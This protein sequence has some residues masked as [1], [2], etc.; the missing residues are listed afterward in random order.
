MKPKQIFILAVIFGLLMAAV[1]VKELQKP[2]E[3]TEEEYISL[4]LSFD[5]PQVAKILIGK[6]QEKFVELLK[7]SHVWRIPELWNA[8]ADSSKVERFLQGIRD[9][10]GELR[11]SDK[12]LFGDFGI[13][14]DKAFSVLLLKETGEPVLK[15]FLGTKK[16][17][18]RFMFVRK[19]GSEKVYLTETDL[20][21]EMG[22]LGDPETQNPQ[23]EHWAGLTFSEL[24]TDKIDRLEARRF[25]KEKETLT[26]SIVRTSNPSDPA[27]KE[28]KYARETV[29]AAMDQ[30]KIK[31]FLNFLTNTYAS[32]VLDPTAYNFG[33]P[34]WQMKIGLEDGK[35]VILNAIVSDETTK[36]YA[37][38]V[39]TEPVAFQVSKYYFEDLDIE[40]SKFFA[41]Q[42]KAQAAPAEKKS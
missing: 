2:A 26:M 23:K 7:S 10:R 31:Q 20:F 3:L 18:Y 4:D 30:E 28:W 25:A 9:A 38:Q 22:I 39:S 21:G 27:K 14:D 36:D 15:L 34:A 37:V 1:L 12:S 13:G 5:S 42:P 40:D 8:R 6:G 41:E 17:D 29:S 16:G 35:E 11:G 32:K 19:E 33:K 24:D